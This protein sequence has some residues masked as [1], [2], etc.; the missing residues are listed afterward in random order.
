MK[1][2]LA[3]IYE[4]FETHIVDASGIDQMDGYTVG[5]TEELILQF[6]KM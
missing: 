2:T 6:K 1:L 3:T 5:P 4:K